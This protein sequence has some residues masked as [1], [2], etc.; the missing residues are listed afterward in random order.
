MT[1]LYQKSKRS[2][3]R[4][5]VPNFMISSQSAHGGPICKTYSIDY[6]AC[7]PDGVSPAVI[8]QCAKD[9]TPS[10]VTLFN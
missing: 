10:L 3:L 4:S 1:A 7:G 9:L 8:K 6:K 5:S 2:F